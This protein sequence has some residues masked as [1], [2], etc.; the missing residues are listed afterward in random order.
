[1][2]TQSPILGAPGKKSQEQKNLLSGH[3]LKLRAVSP[4]FRL[5]IKLTP[6]L[7]NLVKKGTPHKGDMPSLP[8]SADQTPGRSSLI[9]F[10]MIKVGGGG[11]Q[12]F[13]QRSSHCFIWGGRNVVF[14][15]FN[16]NHGTSV[17]SLTPLPPALGNQIA[18]PVNSDRFLR[19]V[20]KQVAGKCS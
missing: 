16:N 1:M 17:L 12:H 11:N 20:I 13:L 7:E 2:E 10:Q 19:I 15:N 8:C 4:L 9:R 14:K 18:L 3:A 6:S 5:Q